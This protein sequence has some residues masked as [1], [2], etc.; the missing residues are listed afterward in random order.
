MVRANKFEVSK[1]S[2]K[3]EVKYKNDEKN[4]S[5]L[6]DMVVLSPALIPA[7]DTPR[8]SELTRV[9][10]GNGG[11]FEEEHEKLGPVSTSTEGVYLA[12]CCQGPKSISDTIVQAGAVTGRILS[13]LIPGKKIEPEVKVSHIS[14]SFCIGCK[15][16]LN[17]CSYGAIT[18]DEKKKISV[19]NEVICRGCG[20]CVAACPSGAATLRHF[21]FN[22]LYQEM[23]EAVK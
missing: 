12:G 10:Q 15:T 1:K 19:V 11:F 4:S 9:S 13:S 17:I 20:N 21:N 2:D 6:V 7:S 16:C 23:K 5:Q 3:L 22:Q 8:F 18:F 14:E